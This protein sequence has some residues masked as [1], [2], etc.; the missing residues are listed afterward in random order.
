MRIL[1]TGGTGMIGKELG[2]TLSAQGHELIILTRNTE[3]AKAVLPYPAKIMTYT[4]SAIPDEAFE[5]VEAIYNLAGENIGAKRWSS[6]RKKKLHASRINMT[7]NLV[8]GVKRQLENNKKSL[9]K[10]ISVSAIGIYGDRHDELLT[11][12]SSSDN[13]F[14][15]QICKDWEKESQILTQDNIQVINP[16]IG[17]VLSSQGGALQRLLPLFTSGIGSA[18]GSG[19]QW[20]SWIHIQDLVSLLVHLLNS[21]IRGAVNAVAPHPVTNLEFSK[22]LAKK[23]NKPLFPKVP[24]LPL[25][26]ALGEISTLV[27][28]SQRVSSQKIQNDGF[29]FEYP[30]LEAAIDKITGPMKN[31]EEEFFTEQWI[32]KK[33][34]E[35]FEFFSDEHNL[36]KIT[37]SFLGFK[38]LQSST[39]KIKENTIIDYRLSLYGIP[40]KWKTKIEEWKPPHQ[41][42]D[43]QLR[44]P[45][46]SWKHTHEL[47]PF[48]GG[49]LLRD[50]VLYKLPLGSIGKLVALRKVSSDVTKIFEFRREYIAREFYH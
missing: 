22:T 41:F 44:G 3:K 37:P 2:K 49:T 30:Q 4:N 17:I 11:E 25:K 23:L 10:F 15:A 29:I 21:H 47:I 50:R 35:V 13:D 45:Y 46:K 43:N 39:D 19:K 18:V 7:Q 28:S 40:V 6:E 27:L 1:I 31:G 24:G 20:M 36:E 26:L 33:P 42:V 34:E 38:V 9:T 5:G 8:K 32:P 12:E 16:R 48:A 14:L